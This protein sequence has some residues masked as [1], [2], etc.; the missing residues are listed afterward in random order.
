MLGFIVDNPYVIAEGRNVANAF[1]ELIALP[2]EGILQRGHGHELCFGIGSRG[3]HV[4]VSRKG[5]IVIEEVALSAGKI[6]HPNRLIGSGEIGIKQ[7][8]IIEFIHVLHEGTVTVIQRTIFVLAAIGFEID[9]VVGTVGITHTPQNISSASNEGNAIGIV[10]FDCLKR[11]VQFIKAGGQ[12]TTNRLDH[13]L[14][15]QGRIAVGFCIFCGHDEPVQITFYLESIRQCRKT[16]NGRS[17]VGQLIPVFAE[18]DE[19]IFCN[20]IS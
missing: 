15:D 5:T 8:F 4:N 19:H 9:A 17:V 12:F 14:T 11:L 13:V 1:E 18:I 16:F 2:T 7:T 10:S 20:V 3:D 6:F